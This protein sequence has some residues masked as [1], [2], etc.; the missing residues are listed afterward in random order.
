[1]L[2]SLLKFCFFNQERKKLA[3]ACSFGN[4]LMIF[5]CLLFLHNIKL[6]TCGLQ[7]K[8]KEGKKIIDK[9]AR[10]DE[11]RLQKIKRRKMK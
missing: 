3:V 8:K 7:S 6:K 4:F 1:M 10:D 5:C 11:M 2:P 9:W